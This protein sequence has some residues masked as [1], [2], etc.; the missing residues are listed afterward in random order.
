MNLALKLSDLAPD[1]KGMLATIKG[2]MEAN[3]K[4]HDDY[5]AARS[6]GDQAGMDI[7]K[8]SY[9]A[10]EQYAAQYRTEAA[11]MGV[12]EEPGDEDIPAAATQPGDRDVGKV[13]AKPD[14]QGPMAPE[15]DMPK[16][17][18]PNP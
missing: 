11:G 5:M 4:G 1:D 9:E 7:N 16:G 12:T 10:F 8:P 3:R 14:P 2:Q 18:K 15:P 6:A 17:V 13:P